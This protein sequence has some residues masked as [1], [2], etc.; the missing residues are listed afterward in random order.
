MRRAAGLLSLALALAVQTPSAL[1]AQ[2]RSV[3]LVVVDGLSFEEALRS[4][5]VTEVA[6]RGGIGLMPAPEE[7]LEPLLSGVPLEAVDV[8]RVDSAEL[9]AVIAGALAEEGDEE[10]LILIVAPI[11]TA[12]MQA[13]GD[14]ATPVALGRIGREGAGTATRLA[15][16]TSDSTRREGVVAP[17]DVPAT[18]LSFLGRPLP[19]DGA[20]IRVE[21]EAPTRLHERYLEVRRVRFPLQVGVL[22][23][24]LAVLLGAF[25][26][27]LLGPRWPGLARALGFWVLTAV[28]L[29]VLLLPISALPDVT[30]DSALATLGLFM[31]AVVLA[32]TWAGRRSPTTA[33][34]VVGAVGLSVLAV[35]A[36]TGWEASMIPVLGGGVFDGSRFFGL[37]NAYAGVLL[38]GVVVVAA[39]LA[40]RAGVVLMVAAALFAGLPG[41]GSN[42]GAA[43]TLFAAAGLWYGLRLRRRLGALELAIAG[44]AALVGTA[45]LLLV[46]GVLAPEVTHIARAAED[47]ARSGPGDLVAT[48]GRRLR[49]NLEVT[50]EVPAAW[51][52]VVALAA[53]TWAAAR[54]WGPLRRDPEWRDAVLAL[55]IA[56]LVGFIANDTGIGVAGLAFVFVAAA[57]AYPALEERWT[58]G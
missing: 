17:E 26:F 13:R 12:S 49:I 51:L 5:G 29:P 33:V 52:V 39:H 57:L 38:G 35:D 6:A 23:F 4:P 28:A 53:A 25:S 11:P 21:G 47:A 1:A 34:A 27:L 37:G 44:A 19:E 56:A 3:L 58:S 54:R 40:P 9:D 24:D 41:L 22:G 8:E 55:S 45:L 30:W 14:R 48:V 10:R 31:V 43:V 16:L 7:G 46:H 15:G 50:N 32:A 2:E 18:V 36:A 42:L 20:A